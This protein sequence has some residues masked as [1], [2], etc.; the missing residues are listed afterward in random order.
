MSD[1]KHRKIIIYVSDTTYSAAVLLA[2]LSWGGSQC[3]DVHI[4]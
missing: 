2:R 3:L 1:I 4:V